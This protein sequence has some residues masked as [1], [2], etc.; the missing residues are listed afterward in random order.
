MTAQNGVNTAL[1][2]PLP[3]RKL[4]NN[5]SLRVGDFAQKIIPDLSCPGGETLGDTLDTSSS[6]SQRVKTG[7]LSGLWPTNPR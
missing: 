2:R 6:D 4:D 3:L 5:L 7:R 1:T